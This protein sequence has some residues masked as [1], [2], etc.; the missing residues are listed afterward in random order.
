MY[1]THNYSAKKDILKPVYMFSCSHQKNGTQQY[2]DIIS[3]HGS[4][5]WLPSVPICI[6][7]VL[8]L[9][10]HALDLHQFET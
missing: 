8:L 5:C 3:H 10:A 7:S 1:L 6:L 4:W 2:I 9:T